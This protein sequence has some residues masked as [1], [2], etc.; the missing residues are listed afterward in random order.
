MR[1]TAEA[2]LSRLRLSVMILV[3]TAPAA[4]SCTHL[5]P[6]AARVVA[7][8]G[9]HRQRDFVPPSLVLALREDLQRQDFSR[10]ASYRSDG[11]EDDLRSALT[12]RVDSQ[13]HAELLDLLDGARQELSHGLGVELSSGFEAT[14][15]VYPPGGYY[16]RHVDAVEG[17]DSSGSGRRACSVVAYL[18]APRGAPWPTDDGGALRCWP[19]GADGEHYEDVLPESGLLVLFDSKRLWHEVSP[20][21]RERAALVGWFRTA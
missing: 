9:V 6:N 1:T 4:K 5:H 10:A 13:S 15:V 17:V 14:F 3:A 2:P 11:S 21:R 8:G 7:A 16:R 19:A 12:C 20:T 18:G